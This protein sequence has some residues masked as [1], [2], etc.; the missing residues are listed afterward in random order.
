MLKLNSS[1]SSVGVRGSKGITCL[2]P[3][4]TSDFSASAD[5]WAAVEGVFG[6]QFNVDGIGGLDNNIRIRFGAST[7]GAPGVISK[8]LAT[9]FT[10]GCTYNYAIKYQIPSGNDE[11]THMTTLGVAGVDV[12]IHSSAQTPDTWVDVSGTFVA[13]T[14]STGVSITFNA[15]DNAG[16]L[17]QTYINTIQIYL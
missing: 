6:I 8:T 15:A 11:V 9:G 1:I 14:S 16:V 17:D 3:S 5:G 10:P 12:A 2:D 7:K 4:Y 13:T